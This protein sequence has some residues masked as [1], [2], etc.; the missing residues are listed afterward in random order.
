MGLIN[1]RRAFKHPLL[2]HRTCESATR[3]PVAP[4]PA[5][6]LIRTTAED[7]PPPADKLPQLRLRNTISERIHEL[8]GAKCVSTVTWP[9]NPSRSQVHRSRSCAGSE[10]LRSDKTPPSLLIVTERFGI[11]NRWR[12]LPQKD[13]VSSL[14]MTEPRLPTSRSAGPH[15]P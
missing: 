4:T 14:S 3:S 2:R 5:P 6:S 15:A 9:A 8:Q 7:S 1:K 13:V 11:D 12:L 10:I